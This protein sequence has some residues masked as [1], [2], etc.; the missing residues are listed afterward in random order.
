LAAHT[1]QISVGIETL[2]MTSPFLDWADES[3]LTIRLP[4]PI[5]SG[6]A[7][8]PEMGKYVAIAGEYASWIGDRPD[9]SAA[10][11]DDEVIVSGTDP[12]SHHGYVYALSAEAGVTGRAGRHGLADGSRAALRRV[13]LRRHRAARGDALPDVRC[14]RRVA[15]AGGALSQRAL[16]PSREVGR[17]K[18]RGDLVRG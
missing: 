7:P 11:R 14:D 1:G 18:R 17:E 5:A 9:A 3:G 10:A 12:G 6:S 8:F 2:D 16:D 13:R 4:R 15:R